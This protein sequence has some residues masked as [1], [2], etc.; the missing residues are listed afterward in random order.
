MF[1]FNYLPLTITVLLVLN[2]KQPKLSQGSKMKG[3]NKEKN[4]NPDVDGFQQNSEPVEQAKGKF[5]VTLSTNYYE[6]S[7][8]SEVSA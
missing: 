4:R 7:N 5:E 2:L 3:I 1:T 6:F 8:V